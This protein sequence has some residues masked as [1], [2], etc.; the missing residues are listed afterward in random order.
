MQKK[1]F[2]ESYYVCSHFPLAIYK[3]RK[4]LFPNEIY[5]THSWHTAR[6]LNIIEAYWYLI[7][8]KISKFKWLDTKLRII[9]KPMFW[10]EL[11]SNK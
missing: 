2:I 5:R 3:Y 7:F 8:I 9:E 11:Q 4:G 6:R 10:W 1:Y